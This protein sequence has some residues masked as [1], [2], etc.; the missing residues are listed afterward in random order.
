MHESYEGA[1]MRRVCDVGARFLDRY[2]GFDDISDE[3]LLHN[4]TRMI[5]SVDGVR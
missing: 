5:Q 2:E 1:L 3:G 4:A